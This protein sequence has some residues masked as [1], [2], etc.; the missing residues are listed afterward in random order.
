M[1]GHVRQFE[2]DQNMCKPHGSTLLTSCFSCRQHR[3]PMRRLSDHLNSKLVLCSSEQMRTLANRNR[4]GLEKYQDSDLV[5]TNEWRHLRTPSKC[6][7]VLTVTCLNPII[8]PSPL[9]KMK[10]CPRQNK[11][12]LT[13][14]DRQQSH[15]KNYNTCTKDPTE[16]N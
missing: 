6:S 3:T 7:L 9:H 10:R 15:L 11:K 13:I 12:G 4:C 5:D 2:P 8:F 16:I 1:K 14:D